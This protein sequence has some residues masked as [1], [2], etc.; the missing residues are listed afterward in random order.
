M[1][2][3]ALIVHDSKDI[4]YEKGSSLLDWA[5]SEWV[6]NILRLICTRTDL[7]LISQTSSHMLTTSPL[8]LHNKTTLILLISSI[9]VVVAGAVICCRSRLLGWCLWSFSWTWT[10]CYVGWR[11]FVWMVMGTYLVLLYFLFVH[12]IGIIESILLRICPSLLLLIILSVL[13][14]YTGRKSSSLLWR[15]HPT[16]TTSHI[17]LLLLLLLLL[18]LISHSLFLFSNGVVWCGHV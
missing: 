14:L 11:V 16:A 13:L 6:H 4:G 12:V 1:T 18:H 15:V 2:N 10:W 8:I 5:I 3:E 9:S 7:I 17:L